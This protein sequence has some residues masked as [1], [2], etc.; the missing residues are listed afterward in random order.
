MKRLAASV[1]F[2]GCLIV[3]IA[4]LCGCDHSRDPQDTAVHGVF[5]APYSEGDHNAHIKNW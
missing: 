3:L 4:C 1:L 2:S 5:H